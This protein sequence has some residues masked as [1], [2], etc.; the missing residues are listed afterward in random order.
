MTEP[1][2][3]GLAVMRHRLAGSGGPL[4]VAFSGGGDSLALLMVARAFAREA[5]RSLWAL[6]VDHDL[7]ADSA[8]WADQAEAVAVRLGVTFA[9]LRWRGEKPLT[10][11]P[12]A[13]RAARH[14]L[15]AEAARAVGARVV[16]LGHTLDDQLE[17]AVMRGAG[18]PV[19]AM[20][21]WS[22]SPVWPE[23]RD[24]FHYRPLLT[25][26]RAALR[27]WLRAEGLDW[28]DDPANA[29]LRYARARARRVVEAGGDAQP[30]VP[31]VDITVL[32]ETSRI[33]PWGGIVLDRRALRA[34]PDGLGLRL[35]QIA[36]ACASGAESLAR[37]ARAR[38][39]LR[40]LQS[41]ETFTTVLAGAR[42]MAERDVRLVREA[43]EAARGGLAPITLAAGE[44][45]VWDGR[46]AFRGEGA[47]CTVRSLAG[48][49]KR[50]DPAD[51]ALVR[52][53]PASDRP[54][55]PVFQDADGRVRL[56]RLATARAVL[57]S[58]KMTPGRSHGWR[59]LI[60]H[61][62]LRRKLRANE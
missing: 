40:R 56:V 33:T 44:A 15:V 43:G 35:I 46:W 29:N 24:I 42:V 53:I 9:R 38:H 54:S 28:V 60:R 31:A 21:E 52:D 20:V 12:A 2:Q 49:A 19:G 47:R 27:D 55:L 50:L 32:A 13:A 26:R 14:R 10:G 11:V 17:N 59:T 8:A 25:M 37:P 57:F 62:M 39:L 22:A 3:T 18:A 51:A 1:L 23:G 34:A 48:L 7:Q 41:P 4:A 36:L 6:H 58:A 30:L 5:G 16:L 45:K 61:P